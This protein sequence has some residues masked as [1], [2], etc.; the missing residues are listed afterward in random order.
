MEFGRNIVT[1]LCRFLTS[2]AYSFE[3][4][5]KLDGWRVASPQVAGLM[6]PWS[7]SEIEQVVDFSSV[8]VV[9]WMRRQPSYNMRC[10]IPLINLWQ[11]KITY[12]H[13]SHPRGNWPSTKF[14]LYNCS[15]TFNISN[16]PTRLDVKCMCWAKG[17][18]VVTWSSS[19][20]RS[21]KA[22]IEKCMS[23]NNIWEDKFLLVHILPIT[24]RSLT[25]CSQFK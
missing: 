14:A 10:I 25:T 23:D 8:L 18:M 24:L 1:L 16:M 15:T 17:E 11:S 4:G 12:H 5:C 19:F 21:T 13:F 22:W 20:K 2:G 7:K 3:Q 9:I 6:L